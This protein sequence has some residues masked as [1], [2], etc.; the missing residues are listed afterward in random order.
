[1]TGPVK[2]GKIDF[3]GKEPGHIGIT[4]S[5]EV[6]SENFRTDWLNGKGG[7]C[8]SNAGIAVWLR[9]LLRI[10]Q[11]DSNWKAFAEEWNRKLFVKYISRC[12]YR[13]LKKRIPDLDLEEWKGARSL[14]E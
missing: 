9:I 5:S 2:A 6:I 3:L 10:A 13:T 14:S 4:L 11:R 1:L 8:Q 7:F 12:D